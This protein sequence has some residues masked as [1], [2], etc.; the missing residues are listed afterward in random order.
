MLGFSIGRVR[1]NSMLPRIS[2]DAFIITYKTPRRCWRVGQMFYIH[3]PRYGRIVKTLARLSADALWFRGESPDS[4]SC[5]AMG[6]IPPSA[7][8]GR[9]IWVLN[10]P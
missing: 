2:P 3:H 5:E 6:E 4:V 1:G 8:I 7:V 10:R 9:V